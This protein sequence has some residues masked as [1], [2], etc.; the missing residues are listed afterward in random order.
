M[1][2]QSF[3]SKRVITLPHQQESKFYTPAE[4]AQAHARKITVAEFVRRDDLVKKLSTECPLQTGD[5]AYPA[6]KKGYE[7]YGAVIVVGITRSYKDFANDTTWPK[8]D[9]PMIVTFAPMND[10]KSHVFCTS[11][12]LVKKNPHMAVC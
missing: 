1:I 10:R 7:E 6:N 8:N 5:T 9:N 2:E 12:Y 3:P 11:N 4:Y